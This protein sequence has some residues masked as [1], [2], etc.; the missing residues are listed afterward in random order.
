MPRPAGQGVVEDLDRDAI[1]AAVHRRATIRRGMMLGRRGV[2]AGRFVMVFV[3][4]HR[5]RR[6]RNGK[7]TL[8]VAWTG[9]LARPQQLWDQE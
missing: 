1:G 7:L 6:N 5:F 9:N 2:L 3:P 4:C 8:T